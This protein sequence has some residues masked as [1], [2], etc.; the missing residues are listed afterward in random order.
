MKHFTGILFLLFLCFSCTAVHDAPLEQALTLAGDNRKE[1]QQVLGH[2]EDDSLKHKAACFLIENMIGKGTIRY[3]LQESDSCYI[4]QEPEPDLTCITADYLIENIDLAF[5]VWQKYS[6]CKQLSFGEFCRNILP[7]RLKQEPLDRWRSYYYMRYKTTADS[8]ARAGATMQEV[9][10]FFNSQHGKKYL[11]D[12]AKIPGDF[13]I[14]LI[15]KLG[16][17]TCDHLALNAVQLMRAVGIPLNLDILPYHGKVN[18][19]HAYNSFT[20]ED[21]KF[22]SFSPYEREPERNQWVAPLVQRV[23]YERQPEPEIGRNRWNAQLVNRLLKGVTAQYY[24]SDSVRLPVCTSDT[25]AYIATFNRG[26]FKVVSQGRVKD[27]SVLHRVLPYGLLYFQVADKEGK[28]FPIG[29]PFVMTPD[30][31]HFI[32]PTRQSTL[33]DGILTY[34][35][36][37]VLKLGDEP[38]TLLYWKDGWQPLKEVTSKDSRTLDFGEVPVRSLFLVYGDTYMGHMQRPFLLEDGKPVYY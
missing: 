20:D 1:L 25:V 13:S 22:F 3:L 6:W 16:G 32:T 2:Y 8:L 14:E 15:E 11:H 9:V 29:D 26:T 30:S 36:K 10:F 7:Y 33:L 12:A 19:G 18:G 24:L 5:E 28:L 35:V 27:N 21:G 34:D 17:G 31:I 38:Y 37:R 23:C 4:R